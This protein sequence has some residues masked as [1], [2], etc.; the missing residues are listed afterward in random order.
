MT[1]SLC[2]HIFNFPKKDKGMILSY[3]NRNIYKRNPRK[4]GFF[5]NSILP[6]LPILTYCLV[7]GNESNES[8]ESNG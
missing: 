3:Q 1:L 2:E 4:K 7:V 8:N 5:K 6:I